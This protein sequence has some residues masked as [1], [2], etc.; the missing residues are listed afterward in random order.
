ML[1]FTFYLEEQLLPMLSDTPHQPMGAISTQCLDVGEA[2]FNP[3]Q[4]ALMDTLKTDIPAE[5]ICSDDYKLAN[6]RNENGGSPIENGRMSQFS[7]TGF[8]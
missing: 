2:K 7:L 3:P 1:T 8:I 6:E 5:I 4:K